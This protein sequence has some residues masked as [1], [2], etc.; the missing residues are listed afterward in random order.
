[1]ST[2]S[3]PRTPKTSADLKAELEA[4]KKKLEELEKRAYAEELTEAI[5]ATNIVGEFNK[6]KAKVQKV[7]DT[8]VLEAI[9]VAVGLKRILV[10]QAEPAK[11]KSSGK[12]R[13][14]SKNS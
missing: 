4:A 8:A 13:K 12:P 2:Y 9:A 10:K 14:N 6:I 11:R 3:K 1:M 5:K 7:S